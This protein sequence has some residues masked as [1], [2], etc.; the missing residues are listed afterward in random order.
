M[1]ATQIEA[2]SPG[3]VTAEKE[4]VESFE[5][6][7]RKN[8]Y[9]RIRRMALYVLLAVFLICALLAVAV[10]VFFNVKTIRISGSGPYSEQD[11]VDA[12]GI[13]IGTNLYRLD[14]DEICT[15]IS[16]KYPLVRSVR[17]ERNVPSTVILRI[18]YDKPAYYTELGEDCLLISDKLRVLEITDD[19]VQLLNR[20][21]G[22]LKIRFAPVRR[23]VVGEKI[24]FKNRNYIDSIEKFLAEITSSD[25]YDKLTSI[26]ASDRFNISIVYEHRLKALLGSENDMNVKLMFFKG[27]VAD[28]GSSSGTVDIKDAETG[29]VIL[30]A[31]TD[32]D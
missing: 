16:E 28:L 26:D 30:S 1:A 6:L 2:R 3:G 19:P 17:V 23:A 31:E 10:F 9:K 7:K 32:F 29:Y 20:Y 11:I 27:I 15:N 18:D 21:P 22:I 12:S 13:E 25:V 4:Y 8:L 24:S 5:R 14:V